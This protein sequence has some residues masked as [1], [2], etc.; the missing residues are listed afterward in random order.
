MS[1]LFLI[2]AGLALIASLICSILILIDAFQDETWKGIVGI[3]CTPYL[4]YY[5][6]FEYEHDYKWPI[7]IGAFGGGSI[8]GGLARQAGLM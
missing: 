8:A 1:A 3:F 7:I 6:V 2:L 5:A 4:L